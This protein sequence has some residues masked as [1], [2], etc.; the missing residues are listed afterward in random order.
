M[1]RGQ[2]FA[3]FDGEV[4]TVYPIFSAALDE[5]QMWTLCKM[6]LTILV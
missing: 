2:L 4:Y 5:Q 3:D 6:S 1:D